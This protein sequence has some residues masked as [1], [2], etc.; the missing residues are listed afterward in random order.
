M[1]RTA[2]LFLVALM[3]A[4][5]TVVAQKPAPPTTKAAPKVTAE[6]KAK[7]KE[8]ADEASE[9]ALL[10]EAKVTEAAARVE[11]LKHVPGGVVKE[12]ELEKE[13]GK[14]IWSYDI[15]V[16]GKSGIEEVHV[17]AITGKMLKHEHE[18]PKD[19]K[20]EAAEDAAKAKAKA[21]GVKKP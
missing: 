18:T 12:H 6:A 5:A 10:K 8:S 19:E 17:D 14:L 3:M 2:R 16:A 13:D 9:K 1:T 20:K 4:P 15:T 21:A 11:A 7:E